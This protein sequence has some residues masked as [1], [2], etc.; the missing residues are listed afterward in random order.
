MIQDP[1]PE[2]QGPVVVVL[3]ADGTQ[4]IY[5]RLLPLCDTCE[6]LA[7]QRDPEH[8]P[9]ADKHRN[10]PYDQWCDECLSSADQEIR[11]HVDRADAPTVDYSEMFPSGRP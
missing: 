7:E 11:E 2:R 1:F 5:Q 3:D 9:L 6:Y 4:H 10:T 8:E